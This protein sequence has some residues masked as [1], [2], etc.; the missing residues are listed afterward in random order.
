MRRMVANMVAVVRA[1]ASLAVTAMIASA[2]RYMLPLPDE[3]AV[4]SRQGTRGRPPPGHLIRR[5]P[6]RER[7]NSE[8]HN[9][10]HA[11]MKTLTALEDH[12]CQES[13]LLLACAGAPGTRH[14]NHTSR[15]DVLCAIYDGAGHQTS[16]LP[17]QTSQEVL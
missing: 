10:K 2:Q 1:P 16:R 17:N 5:L 14:S 6:R 9:Q 15:Q 7:S 4:R 8:I 13:L 3:A 12:L 11:A